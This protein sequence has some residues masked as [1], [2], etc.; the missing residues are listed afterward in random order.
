VTQFTS[1][2]FGQYRIRYSLQ[3][4]KNYLLENI[5]SP[6][7]DV[8]PVNSVFFAKNH[9]QLISLDLYK[10]WLLISCFKDT[11]ISQKCIINS[12]FLIK[13]LKMLHR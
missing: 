1:F 4:V 9:N 10:K 7:R 6:F 13:L 11:F 2:L 12:L 3:A 8:K 5:E